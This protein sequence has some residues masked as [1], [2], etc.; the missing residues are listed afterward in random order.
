MGQREVEQMFRRLTALAVNLK[1]GRTFLELANEWLATEARALVRQTDEARNVSYL[2]TLWSLR[3]GELTP[4]TVKRALDGLLK[5]KGRL[6][7]SSVNQVRSTGRRIVRAAMF[8]G[9]WIMPN[10]FELVRRHKQPEPQ[11]PDITIR[12]VKKFMRHLRADR[13]REALVML[14]LGPRPGELRALRKED[15]SGRNRL[16]TIRRSNK[17]NATKTGKNRVIPIPRKLWPVLMSAVR[18]SPSDLVFPGVDG[19]MQRHDS[20]L[21]RTLCDALARSGVVTGWRY[22]CR[23]NWGCGKEEVRPMRERGARCKC[24]A[25][26]YIHG[27]P[28]RLRYYDLRHL[29]ATLHRQAG[30]DPL[31]IQRTLGHTIRSTTDRVYTHLDHAYTRR[32]LSKLL[33]V[34]C[35]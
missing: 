12:D 18:D 35:D 6:A 1:P 25:R 17:R 5:P 4:R 16:V 27:I 15:I 32:E 30:C 22:K 13:Q 3:E 34:L 26:F 14:A 33:A 23:L 19:Q 11:W 20:K 28:P 2:Q 24:G 29:S 21:G 31:V 9:E 7:P 8:N 10:P